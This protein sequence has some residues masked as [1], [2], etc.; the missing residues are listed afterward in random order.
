M[1]NKEE[2]YI[3][4]DGLVLAIPMKY[5]IWDELY[6]TVDFTKDGEQDGYKITPLNR[7]TWWL[8]SELFKEHF[9]K[10][11]IDDFAC[12]GY[13]ISKDFTF[14]E[15][16]D[17]LNN[18]KIKQTTIKTY[19]NIPS[20]LCKKYLYLNDMECIENVDLQRDDVDGVCYEFGTVVYNVGGNLLGIRQLVW[21]N[22]QS[23]IS[24]F[25]H[26]LEFYKMKEKSFITYEKV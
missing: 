3:N 14:S 21:V 6:Q 16:I 25:G 2:L 15:L 11:N 9:T 19:K 26:I 23:P 20:D 4:D 1:E 22:S 18:R 17:E 24:D 13:T 10:I 12:F 5:K 8:K 7:E